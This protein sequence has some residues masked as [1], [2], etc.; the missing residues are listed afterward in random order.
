[1]ANI[2]KYAVYDGPGIR[3]VVYLKG[4]PLRC[5]WCSSPQTQSNKI[6]KTYNGNDSSTETIGK[7]LTVNEVFEEIKKDITFY[8]QSDGGVTISGGE[9]LSQSGF[10]ARLLEKCQ[11]EYIHTAIE[12]SGYGAWDDFK[13]IL[14]YADLVLFDIK[15]LN[16]KQHLK[17]TGVENTLILDNLEKVSKL[18]NDIIIRVPIIPGIN[19]SEEHLNSIYNLAFYSGIQEVH[20]LPYHT[21]GR[22]N[23]K[24]LNRKY[25]L[26]DLEP[27]KKDE[28][29]SL[30]QLIASKGLDVKVVGGVNILKE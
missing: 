20:L 21:L 8:N 11:Q 18:D 13:R 30:K 19:D 25:P 9:V 26:A 29:K 22:E 4:C 14:K 28:I 12:T 6:E 7:Y 3:T 27:P 1:M 15:H 10:A 5:Q 24:K 17:V 2:E 16:N 23:Y